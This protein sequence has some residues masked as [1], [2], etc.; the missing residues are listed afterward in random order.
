MGNN[1]HI[2][3]VI[4][5]PLLPIIDLPNLGM[6][7]ELQFSIQRFFEQSASENNHLLCYLPTIHNLIKKIC[8]NFQVS[9]LN[10]S[11]FWG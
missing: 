8:P 7:E 1:G 3:T 2:I 4:M 11:L 10:F 6:L 5:D 9:V